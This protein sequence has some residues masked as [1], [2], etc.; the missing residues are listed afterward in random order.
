MRNMATCMR[1][2][3]LALPTASTLLFLSQ[4]A[5]GAYRKLTGSGICCDPSR[6]RELMYDWAGVAGGMDDEAVDPGKC[7]VALMEYSRCS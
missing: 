1:F 5:V 4:L 7:D 2:V 6:Q 3:S